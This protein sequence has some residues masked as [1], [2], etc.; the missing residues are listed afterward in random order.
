MLDFAGTGDPTSPVFAPPGCDTV[1]QHHGWFYTPGMAVRTLQDM[2]TVYH[3][4]V[5]RN[6]VIELDFA[7]DREGAPFCPQYRYVRRHLFSLSW[8]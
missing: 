2:Q 3:Q 1:L 6:C 7:I 4:T 5:G 8:R